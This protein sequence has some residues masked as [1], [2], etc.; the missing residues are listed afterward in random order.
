MG[1]GRASPALKSVWK[2]LTPHTP[3]FLPQLYSE[4]VPACKEFSVIWEALWRSLGGAVANAGNRDGAVVGLGR[5]H[6]RDQRTLVSWIMRVS[7][8]AARGGGP[9]MWGRE[10]D[11]LD[12]R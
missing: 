2:C 7:S 10:A 3:V 5:V 9:R 4:S 6:V 11:G 1:Q 12:V 8:E